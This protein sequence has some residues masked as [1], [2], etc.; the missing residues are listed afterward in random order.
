MIKPGHLSIIDLWHLN[1]LQQMSVMSFKLKMEWNEAKQTPS[2]IKHTQILV[3]FHFYLKNKEINTIII[4]HISQK[5][6]QCHYDICE[7]SGDIWIF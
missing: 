1:K 4:F 5:Q 7:S 3:H 2:W 6:C